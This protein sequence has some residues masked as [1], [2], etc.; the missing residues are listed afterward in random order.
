[1]SLL[2]TENR[3][4][5]STVQDVVFVIDA[6]GSIRADRFQL[7][8]NF[9]ANVT[10]ELI[11][12]FPSSAVGVILFNDKAHIEFNLTVHTNLSSLLSAINELPYSG[13]G[14]DIAEAL[15]LLLKSAQNG[16]LGLRSNSLNSAIVITDGKSSDPSATE[17]AANELHDSNIFDVYSIGV[18]GADLTELQRIASSPEFVFFTSSFNSDGLQQLNEEFLPHLCKGEQ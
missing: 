17:S 1:M 15:S 14:T 16:G 9:T 13:G 10:M 3:C 7:I 5:C 11:N 2:C 6:S 12:R 4:N 18:G 8:R